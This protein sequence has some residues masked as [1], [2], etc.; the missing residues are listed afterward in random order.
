MHCT[1]S[2]SQNKTKQKKKHAT[3]MSRDNAEYLNI[4]YCCMIG[5]CTMSVWHSNYFELSKSCDP[6]RRNAK[7]FILGKEVCISSPIISQ[8]ATRNLQYTRNRGFEEG[9]KIF[10]Q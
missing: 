3:H 7:L 6:L 1:Q 2:Q 5:N 10:V 8:G 4:L 9:M